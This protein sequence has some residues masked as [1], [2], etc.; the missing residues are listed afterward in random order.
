MRQAPVILYLLSKK[1]VSLPFP[2][3]P[4]KEA[5]AAFI[6]NTPAYF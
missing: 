3:G 2:D 1:P 5:R 6:K 4:A